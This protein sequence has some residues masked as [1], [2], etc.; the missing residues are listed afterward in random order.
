M[1]DGLA[2]GPVPA[3]IYAR[4]S[5]EMQ[6][7]EGGGLDDQLRACLATCER[8][9][10]TVLGIFRDEGF[11]GAI[12]DR[13][14]FQQALAAVP[15]GGVLVVSQYDR[16]S[17]DAIFRLGLPR[18]LS[19]RNV[20]IES[21]SQGRVDVDSASGFLA[22][23]VDAVFS[24][25]LRR[26]ISEHTT[27]AFRRH[28]REGRQHGGKAPYG[29]EWGE[30]KQLLPRTDE[31]E[32]VQRIFEWAAE[33]SG[34]AKIASRLSGEGVPRPDG[35]SEP[36]LDISVKHIIRNPVYVGRVAHCYE[37]RS[38]AGRSPVWQKL[39]PDRWTIHEGKH[40]AIISRELWDGVQSLVRARSWHAPTNYGH[41]FLLTGLLR[42]PYCGGR[43]NGC[44]L[45][46]PTGR[47]PV[48]RCSRQVHTH[49]CRGVCRSARKWEAL[50]L[51]DLERILAGDAILGQTWCYG[52]PQRK[53]LPAEAEIAALEA[54]QQRVAG[55]LATGDWPREVLLR[56]MGRFEARLERLRA[57]VADAEQ[58]NQGEQEP[59]AVLSGLRE[60]LT[61]PEV[62][63]ARKRAVLAEV[64]QQIDWQNGALRTTF[65]PEVY[66]TT[67]ET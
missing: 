59:P 30:E 22:Y 46:T 4:V 67:D 64:V 19:D 39:P 54:Q 26:I 49:T 10:Y 40:P 23:A 1:P 8:N 28:R 38:R 65:R 57:S 11:S 50:F 51:D 60:V 25:T 45:F 6:A 20:A 63:M 53:S 29:Y 55:E 37:K 14:A 58:E 9:G 41:H 7:T 31:A 35:S 13:R 21:H 61:S 42:C 17:R 66:A 27:E 18:E 56:E 44:H 2:G 32:V 47:Y 62:P 12:E 33:G 36:W 3:V 43:M 16:L 5:T 34:V 24:E 52:M 15:S 48:Y